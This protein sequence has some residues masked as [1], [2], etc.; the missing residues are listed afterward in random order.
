M[1][2]N[3]YTAFSVSRQVSCPQK[4]ASS[5]APAHPCPI[6]DSRSAHRPT[7]SARFGDLPGLLRALLHCIAPGS[8]I[9]VPHNRTTSS[10]DLLL[11]QYLYQRWVL[12]LKH[13]LA[14]AECATI[15]GLSPDTVARRLRLIRRS[16][17]EKSSSAPPSSRK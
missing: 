13:D 11:A 3:L 1:S 8:T 14:V 2:R 12:G 5:H 17:A 15:C 16:R 9:Y 4:P 10:D 6:P 7:A